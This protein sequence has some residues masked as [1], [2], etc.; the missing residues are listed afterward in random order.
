M[1]KN[2][3]GVSND[4]RMKNLPY[5]RGRVS[6]SSHMAFLGVQ[7]NTTENET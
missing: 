2:Y 1:E 6:V 4:V 3:E 7:T 5:L